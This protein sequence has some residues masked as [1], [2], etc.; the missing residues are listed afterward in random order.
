MS[1]WTYL[2]RHRG[3]SVN[4]SA[5]SS[6]LNDAARRPVLRWTQIVFGIPVTGYVYSPFRE[7]PNYAPVAR[8]AAFALIAL[9]GLWIGKAHLIRGPVSK[10]SA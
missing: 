6:T 9:S 2:N 4:S 7:L 5:I 3:E 1:E 8:Y 10:T